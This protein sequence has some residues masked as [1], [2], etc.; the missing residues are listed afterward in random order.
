MPDY[1][2]KVYQ[3]TLEVH[4][5]NEPAVNL[6]KMFGFKYLGDYDIYIIRDVSKL[7]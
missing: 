7:L 5:S 4:K 2:A 1:I 3:V 6:Y